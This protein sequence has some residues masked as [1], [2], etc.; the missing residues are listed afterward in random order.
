MH[1]DSNAA[2]RFVEARSQHLALQYVTTTAKKPDDASRTQRPHPGCA[3]LWPFPARRAIA[4]S[5][6][7]TIRRLDDYRPRKGDAMPHSDVLAT[8]MLSRASTG[9]RDAQFHRAKTLPRPSCADRNPPFENTQSDAMTRRPTHGKNFCYRRKLFA[10]NRLQSPNQ[11][12][13]GSRELDRTGM[14]RPR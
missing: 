6:R 11:A 3:S 9:A 8:S 5:K 13:N 7:W 10:K 14:I 1:A 4:P 12:I 2:I